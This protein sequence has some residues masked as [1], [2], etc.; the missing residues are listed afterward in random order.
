MFAGGW[1]QQLGSLLGG[2]GG[3]GLQFRGAPTP[4]PPPS[5]HA[6]AAAAA[7]AAVASPEWLARSFGGNP[8]AQA[9]YATL[10]GGL[11]S[12]GLGAGGVLGNAKAALKNPQLREEITIRNADSGKSK[13]KV[14]NKKS[15]NM[16][17][18]NYCLTNVSLILCVPLATSL[19]RVRSFSVDK[20]DSF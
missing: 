11:G 16:A 7:A 19:I 12:L 5:P 1:S 17:M 8:M 13:Q 4:P 18:K 14:G 10:A 2:G 15:S 3:D 20:I 9:A 6:M